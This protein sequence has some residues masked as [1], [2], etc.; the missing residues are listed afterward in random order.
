[1]R[2]NLFTPKPT[3][4]ITH[5]WQTQPSRKK[6][7]RCGETPHSTTTAVDATLN[8]EKCADVQPARTKMSEL[9]DPQCTQIETRRKPIRTQAND[10]PGPRDW[11]VHRHAQWGHHPRNPDHPGLHRKET[12]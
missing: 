5:T 3:E 9:F 12:M 6:K 11:K 1:M 8:G 7:Q 4:T 2:G 10:D